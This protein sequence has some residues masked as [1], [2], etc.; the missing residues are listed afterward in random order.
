MEV[1]SSMIGRYKR[2]AGRVLN[3]WRTV[4]GTLLFIPGSCQRLTNQRRH[5]AQ[6]ESFFQN[7]EPIRIQNFDKVI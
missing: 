1:Y 2:L 5:R 4:F 6:G 7:Y 3:N